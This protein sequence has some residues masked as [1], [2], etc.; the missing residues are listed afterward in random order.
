[1]ENQNYKKQ[2]S[3]P[4]SSLLSDKTIRYLSETEPWLKFFSIIG[5]VTSGITFFVSFYFLG[6]SGKTGQ[7][8]GISYEFFVFILY[9]IT[10]IIIFIPSKYLYNSAK[11]I[12]DLLLLSRN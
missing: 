5:F 1:M 11:K 3:N 4:L 10:S 6:S 12:K 2:E 8:L 7:L 9:F